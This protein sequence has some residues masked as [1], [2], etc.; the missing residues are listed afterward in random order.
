MLNRKIARSFIA[1]AFKSPAIAIVAVLSVV[2]G[3]FPAQAL[4]LDPTNPTMISGEPSPA[5]TI[6]TRNIDGNPSNVQTVSLEFLTGNNRWTSNATCPAFGSPTSTLNSCGV[7]SVKSTDNGGAPADQTSNV[8]V[9]KSVGGGIVITFSTPLP[10][11][12]SPN[13]RVLEIALLDGA[14]TAPTV[15]ESLEIKLLFSSAPNGI[16][17]I[18]STGEDQMISGYSAVAFSGGTG[19]VGSMS[20]ILASS[21]SNL[22]ANSYSKSGFNFAGWS[23]TDGGPVRFNDQ[24]SIST[25]GF[26]CETLY[27]VWAP[28]GGGSGGG[29]GSGSG[30]GNS[31]GNQ[32]SETGTGDDLF[33][34]TMFTGGLF[35]LLG[36]LAYRRRAMSGANAQD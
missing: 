36:G 5:M 35:L 14:F 28:V 15:I 25:L 26:G 7:L 19:S 32:L 12:V 10:A 3:A 33:A 23:C 20:S 31:D 6:T 21:A 13:S 16:G 8:Q 24:A 1:S 30:G 29:S 34:A 27:A 17:G 2:F 22:P 11:L 18:N 4:T 9:S